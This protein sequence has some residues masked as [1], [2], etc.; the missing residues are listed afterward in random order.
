MSEKTMTLQ[1]VSRVSLVIF[2]AVAVMLVL[3]TPVS[4]EEG[5]AKKEYF[6]KDGYH[7]KDK[8]FFKKHKKFKAR[9]NQMSKGDIQE[10][11][12]KHTKLR[13]QRRAEFESFV[14][15]SKEE[16]R[17]ARKSGTS[18]GE[19]LEQ[20]GKTQDDARQFLENRAEKKLNHVKEKK[21]ISDERELKI[22]ERMKGFV[23][24]MLS[25]WFK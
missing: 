21:D 17:K 23:Q 4:A 25:K 8:R 10:L 3:A 14:G 24:R 6:K 11:K 16:I 20:S 19:L 7:L 5:K 12:A 13:K 22:R 18:V 9:W 1:R 2:M 15:K